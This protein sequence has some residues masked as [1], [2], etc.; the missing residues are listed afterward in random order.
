M[1]M[2]IKQSPTEDHLREP[3][4]PFQASDTTNISHPA[5]P[6]IVGV[7]N[8]EI[9]IDALPEGF[10]GFYTFF[11]DG[12]FLDVNAYKETN[13]G[14]WMDAG[15]TYVLIVW[16][17]LFDENGQANGKATV[18][19]SICMDDADHFTAEGVTDT[20]D[21]VGKPMKNPFNGPVK[22]TGTRMQ[23]ELP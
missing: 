23:I 5:T 3:E 1:H 20:F 9:K 19:A 6:G 10:E 18:R 4:L 13:S 14:N 22:I 17:F 11:A 21:M 8:V 7:W 12:N 2:I 16:G 15:N